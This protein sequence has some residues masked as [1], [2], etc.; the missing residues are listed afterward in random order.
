MEKEAHMKGRRSE[1]SD[2]RSKKHSKQRKESNQSYGRKVVASLGPAKRTP[3]PKWRPGMAGTAPNGARFVV[4]GA[5]IRVGGDRAWRTNNPGN[6]KIGAFARAN[7][8]IGYDEYYAIFPDELTGTRALTSLLQ[9]SAY[10]QMTVREVLLRHV[11]GLEGNLEANARARQFGLVPDSLVGRIGKHKLADLGLAIKSTWGISRPRVYTRRAATKPPWARNILTP[12]G[13]GTTAGT[14]P[15]VCYMGYPDNWQQ[16]V[17]Y[18][19]QNDGTYAISPD[20][21]PR[22]GA[23]GMYARYDGDNS[24]SL[25]G[26]DPS[27]APVDAGNPDAGNAVPP[28]QPTPNWFTESITRD[29]GTEYTRIVE[30]YGSTL[31]NIPP[32]AVVTPLPDGSFEIYYNND[33]K[34]WVGTETEQDPG[35]VNPPDG[36]TIMNPPDGGT[37]LNPPDGGTNQPGDG[38]VGHGFGSEGDIDPESTGFAIP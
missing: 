7:G 20:Q 29:D 21:N 27:Q 34:P 1:R 2:K 4:Y 31:P 32:N 33:G 25:V 5:H 19:R 6:I 38:G 14:P 8:A 36:G 17:W 26:R 35:Q 16:D 3:V 37:I 30:P 18:V 11:S 22:A 9:T 13:P 23:V 12:A 24:W 15:P 10:S 28:G